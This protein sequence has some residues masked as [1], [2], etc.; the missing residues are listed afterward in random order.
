MPFVTIRITGL[1]E[2]TNS[3]SSIVSQIPQTNKNILDE[4]QKFM[5][6]D[7]KSN[8]HVISGK[9]RDSTQGAVLNNNQAVVL[10]SYGAPFEENRS[11]SKPPPHIG[12]GTGSHKKL[13]DAAEKTR[14]LMPSIIN[15]HYDILL[16][17]NNT[18]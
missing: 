16:G 12:S 13:L 6:K 18:L 5:V 9:T 7:Y 17:R 15:K 11:G 10:A 14:I 8:V 2:I 3:L 1:N 4:A